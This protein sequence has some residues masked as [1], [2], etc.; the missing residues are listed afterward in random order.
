MT[1]TK[2]W[3]SAAVVAA[4]TGCSSTPEPD[5]T[6][7]DATAT[8]IATTTSTSTAATTATTTVEPTAPALI[9]T[10][11][12]SKTTI[13]SQADTSP[14]AKFPFAEFEKVPTT[15]K[16]GE[17]ALVPSY[18][19]IA[20]AAKGPDKVTFI[21]YAQVVAKTDPLASEIQF[22]SERKKVP[23]AYV[24]PIA[25]GQKAAKGDVVLTWW[26]TGSGMQRAIVVDASDP[27]SPVVRYLDLDWDNPAKAADGKTSISQV[28]EKLVPDSF[29]KLTDG[30]MGTS[31][32]VEDAGNTIRETYL[33]TSGDKVLTIGWAGKLSSRPKAKVK[34]VPVVPGVKEGDKV[35]SHW[36]ST[37]KNGTVTKVDARNGRV[38]VKFDEAHLGE[39]VV[40]YGDLVKR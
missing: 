4:M 40:P 14:V 17:W 21:W 26:Q 5:T 35:F 7:V 37:F 22:M 1:Q 38:W 23:N 12:A 30:A 25:A 27:A 34:Q 33:R 10:S 29:V 28:D 11:K 39:K 19:W 31:L 36:T 15:A 6:T 18:N 24:V 8:A 2:V 3:M 13:N 20:D 9:N 32:M 16:D